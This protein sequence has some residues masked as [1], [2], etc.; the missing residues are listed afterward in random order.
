MLVTGDGSFG[1]Y[2]IEFEAALRQGLPFVAIVGHNSAWGLEYNLQQGLYDEKYILAT[3]LSTTRFDQV[4][5]AL[6]GP[7]E[8]VTSL[9]DLGPALDRALASGLPA[10]IEVPVE[11]VPSPLTDAVIS[12][13]GGV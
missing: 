12:R 13:G 3:E 7:G 5:A 1:Y 9:D 4:I 8:R 6:G 10:C 11:R 2:L